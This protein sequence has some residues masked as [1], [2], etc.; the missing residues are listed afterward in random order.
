MVPGSR[1]GRLW[2]V[3]TVHLDEL[4][5]AGEDVLQLLQGEE[6][7]IRHGLVEE[8]MQYPQHAHVSC[9][10]HQQL[11]GPKEEASRGRAQAESTGSQPSNAETL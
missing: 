9:L 5:Q 3:L 11:C 4:V 2:L 8:V 6:A 1:P 7:A 10:C